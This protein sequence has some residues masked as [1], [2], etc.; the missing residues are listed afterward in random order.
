MKYLLICAV[1]AGMAGCSFNNVDNA[2]ELKTYFDS[3]HV[4]G[5]FCLYDNG[6]GE[7]TLY[8]RDWYLKR[9]PPG[10][11]FNLLTTLIGVQTGKVFDEKTLIGGTTLTEAF[12]NDSTAYFMALARMLGKDTM[13]R[14]IGAMGYGNMDTTGAVDSLALDGKLTISPDEQLGM[15]KKLYFDL[16]P[17][18]HR[19][20]NVVKG[21][22]EREKNE[23]YTLAYIQSPGWVVG[24]IQEGHHP[25]FFVLSFEGQA[26]GVPLAKDILKGQGFFK[27]VK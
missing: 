17:F 1:L 9:F 4:K 21:L 6:R 18:Q 11:T 12:R 14:R 23:Q 13:D 24:W 19:T 25:Y 7:F 10:A 27:G 8:N 16:L 22:M 3:A 2:D 26:E 20:Q 5:C 15:I